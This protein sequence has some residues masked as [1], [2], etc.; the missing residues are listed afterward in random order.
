MSSPVSPTM[1]FQAAWHHTLFQRII[2]IRRYDIIDI[3]SYPGDYLYA[4]A[5]NGTKHTPVNR[6]AD[7]NSDII[8]VE[9]LN[10]V[11]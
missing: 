4:H 9:Q 8:P 3:P 1:S 10:Q 7:K 6:P 11:G 5:F 2:F